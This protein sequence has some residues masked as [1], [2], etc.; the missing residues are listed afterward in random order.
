MPSSNTMFWEAK[1][2]RN[3]ARDARQRNELEAEGWQ[4][5]VVWECETKDREALVATLEDRLRQM[6]EATGG[7]PS[8]AP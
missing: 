7:K 2:E 8:P 4:V 3:V 5:V 6:D 1:F